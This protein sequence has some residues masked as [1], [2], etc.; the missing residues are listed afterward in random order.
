MK[1]RS[2]AIP[3]LF[4]MTILCMF[5][6]CDD[7][8]S[9][10][11]AS[12]KKTEP[13]MPPYT[14]TGGNVFAFRVDGRLVIAEDRLKR[15][16][17]IIAIYSTHI[18]SSD[19]H[20]YLE[21]FYQTKDRYESVVID[22]EHVNDTGVYI[23]RLSGF[24]GSNNQVKYRIGTELNFVRAYVTT[25]QSKGYVH[26]L[27]IDRKKKIISGKFSFRGELFMWGDDV[28]LVTDGQFD[29]TYYP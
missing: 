18:D 9:T 5:F 2:K 10:N 26:I 16:D 15:T 4:L 28:V 8:S 29:A 22:I 12:P 24:N 20:L 27:K 6:A 7:S 17:G 3:V 23:A 13:V 19:A 21:G 1:W 14:D 11:A 25:D